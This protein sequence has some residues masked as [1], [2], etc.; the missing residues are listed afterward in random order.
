[1]ANPDPTTIDEIPTPA[2][3]VERS[4]FESN[5]AAMDAVRPGTALR[6]HVKA[7]KSTALAARLSADGHTGFCCAT[8]R[9]VEGLV[10]AG[11][12]QD[13]LLANESLDVERLGR[14]A[15]EVVEIV[16]AFVLVDRVLD[17]GGGERHDGRGHVDT[18]GPSPCWPD[19]ESHRAIWSPPCA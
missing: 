18:V 1:M 11:L 12:G 13:V 2:L 15:S 6:P 17:A 7:F 4:V 3:L 16:A 14:L 9:E 5:L 10:D 8:P 19:A